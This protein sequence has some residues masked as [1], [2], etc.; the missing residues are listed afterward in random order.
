MYSFVKQ[1][2]VLAAAIGLSAACQ[3][4]MAQTYAAK[5]PEAIITPDVLETRRLGSLRFFDGMPDE[6]TVNKVY[7]NL[8]F[9]R[10]G[11]SPRRAGFC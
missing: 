3:A 9:S 2:A 10:G 5:T 6:D 8:D 1:A 11:D 4:A 7:D